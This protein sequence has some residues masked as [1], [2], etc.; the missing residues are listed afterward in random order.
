MKILKLTLPAV[1]LGAAVVLSTPK[2]SHGFSL[3][4][5]SL[6]PN[7]SEFRVFNNFQ[8]STANNNITPNDNFPGALGAVMAIWKGV[9]EW[10]SELHGDGTGDPHQFSGLGSGNSNFDPIFNGEANSVGF[11]GSN[12]H[13]AIPNSNGGGTL[14]FQQGG[15]GGWWIRYYEDHTWADG[16]GTS[17]P[18]G[19]TDIQSVACHE[20]G[21]AL[22]L[23][24]STN[25]SATMAPFIQSG[26]N[27]RSINN[28]DAAGIQAIYGNK[29]DSGTKPVITSVS[30]TGNIVTITGSNFTTN[31]N[32]VWF[33]RDLSGGTVVTVSGVSS[34]NGGT[35]IDVLLPSA[36]GSGEVLVKRNSSGQASTSNAWPFDLNAGPPPPPLPEITS[37]APNLVSVLEPTGGALVTLN[38]SNFANLQSVTVNGVEVG[39]PS[40]TFTGEILSATDSQIQFLTPLTPSAGIVTVEVTTVNGSGSTQLFVFPTGTEGVLTTEPLTNVV[41]TD[42]WDVAVSGDDLDI[43]LLY[44]SPVLGT[45]SVPGFWEMGM[46]AGDLANFFLVTS[47]FIGPELWSKKTLGPFGPNDAPP[48]TPLHFECLVAKPGFAQDYAFPWDD[49]NTHTVIVQ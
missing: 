27:A 24:H 32:E 35:Q 21:H 33:T 23:N 39:D 25:N 4:G 1:A 5:F 40:D 15:S 34:T 28:D 20:H 18:F 8:D 26:V 44:F 38:G 46:G 2:E 41:L 49:T 47:F 36:A 43:F 3:L 7:Q 12:I 30:R 22:G 48:G 37:I 19:Q 42:G 9:A 17:I 11:I 10:K 45:T 31:N 6:S 16:P 14:A 13:S 29:N